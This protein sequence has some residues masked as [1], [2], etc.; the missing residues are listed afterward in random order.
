MGMCVCVSVCQC[1]GWTREQ[2]A[3]R[4]V[5][6]PLPWEGGGDAEEEGTERALK[7]NN[8]GGLGYVCRGGT[9][10]KTQRREERS[11]WEYGRKRDGGSIWVV[12][13][14]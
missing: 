10:E 6:L 8:G 11:G 14:D 13:E 7:K 12:G 2:T 5:D 9:E 1:V 3:G 4:G